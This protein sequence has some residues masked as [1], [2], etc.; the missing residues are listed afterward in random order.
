MVGFYIRLCGDVSYTM[1]DEMIGTYILLLA[2][3]ALLFVILTF[4]AA[5]FW[6][7]WKEGNY[8]FVIFTVWI[9]AVLVGWLLHSAGI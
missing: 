4:F 5:A 8:G 9:V 1:G 2:G 6:E 3:S 7:A